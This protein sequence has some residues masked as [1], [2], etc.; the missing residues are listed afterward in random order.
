MI[1][2]QRDSICSIFLYDSRHGLPCLCLLRVVYNPC[3]RAESHEPSMQ[4]ICHTH[5]GHFSIIVR[6]ARFLELS[7]SFIC[8]CSVF[9]INLIVLVLVLYL[10]LYLYR[11]HPLAIELILNVIQTLNRLAHTL[12]AHIL[13]A[14]TLLAHSWLEL[15]TQGVAL[16]FHKSLLTPYS[17]LVNQKHM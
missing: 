9:S 12:L 16:F 17:I 8:A 5:A 1:L 3:F 13:L 14:H 11:E 15:S 7:M 10:Y 6:F 4:R 2:N